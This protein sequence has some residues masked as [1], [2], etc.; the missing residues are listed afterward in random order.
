[1][2][3]LVVFETSPEGVLRKIEDA[4]G[5]AG[6]SLTIPKFLG[7]PAVQAPILYVSVKCHL[8]CGV[9]CHFFDS[10]LL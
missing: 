8:W 10:C 5:I 6:Q 9:N 3:V 4:L 2:H 7:R 1:M